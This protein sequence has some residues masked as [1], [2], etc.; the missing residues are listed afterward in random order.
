MLCSY[1]HQSEAIKLGSL[2]KLQNINSD[3]ELYH[4]M[5]MHCLNE[6]I[7]LNQLLTEYRNYLKIENS[8]SKKT[9]TTAVIAGTVGF[10]SG[11]AAT[12]ATFII[13]LT[14]TSI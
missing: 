6:S 8:K 9:V 14:G 11:I 1:A 10:F 5:Q 4:A 3:S 2:L 13:L 7:D 12:I